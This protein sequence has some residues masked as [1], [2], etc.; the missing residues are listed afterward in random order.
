MRKSLFFLLALFLSNS[1]ISTSSAHQPRI[2]YQKQI[3]QTSPFIVTNPEISQAFYAELKKQAEYY[4]VRSDKEF[5][6]Y[7]RIL[8]P[9]IADAKKD[10]SVEII[11]D[12]NVIALLNGSSS[13]WT[14]FY[15]PF[16]GDDYWQGPEYKEQLPKGEYLIKVYNL[17]NRGKYVLVVGQAESFPLNETLKLFVSLPQLKHYFGKSRFTAFFNLVGLFLLIL[18]VIS[19]IVVFVLIRAFKIMRRKMPR[20]PL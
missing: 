2:V 17:D 16:V 18:T 13:T 10:F 19:A 1:F 9:K 7:V 3:S 20:T 4:T 6:L 11:K 5:T 14:E 8:S 15:E 12:V